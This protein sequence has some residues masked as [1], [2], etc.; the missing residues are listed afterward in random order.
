MKPTLRY[1]ELTEESNALDYLEKAATFLR[2]AERNPM[3]WKWVI[4]ALFG[5][6]YGFMICALK[7]T[8][9][10]NVLLAKKKG[11]PR[12]IDFAEAFRR[13]KDPAWMNMTVYSKVLQ[14]SSRQEESLSQIRELLRNNFE[15]YQPCNW[16]IELHGMPQIAIDAL[17]VIRFLSLEAGNY[18]RLAAQDRTRIEELVAGSQAFL[19]GTQLFGEA[20]IIEAQAAGSP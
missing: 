17:D 13:C 4:L 5:A 11:G 7:G 3:D 15:H 14:L 16:S 2:S 6:L 8:N 9:L 19:R 18:T 20:Q 10:D 12:L 1:L